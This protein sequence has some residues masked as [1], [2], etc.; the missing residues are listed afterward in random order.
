MRPEGNKPNRIIEIMIRNVL[1]G[2]KSEIKWRSRSREW[3]VCL[4]LATYFTWIR[5][6]KKSIYASQSNSMH[7]ERNRLPDLHI[8]QSNAALPN[9]QELASRLVE[10]SLSNDLWARVRVVN[11]RNPLLMTLCVDLTKQVTKFAPLGCKSNS[12]S[13]CE[14]CNQILILESSHTFC[15]DALPFL[16]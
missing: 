13:I 9:F 15:Q 14:E 10:Q 1:Y 12:A 4:K 5:R 6:N 11:N 3:R 8:G 2:N 7:L 16:P